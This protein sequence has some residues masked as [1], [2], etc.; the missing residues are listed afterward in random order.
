MKVIIYNPIGNSKGH[1]RVYTTGIVNGFL[2]LVFSTILITSEDFNSKDIVKG[3]LKKIKINQSTNPPINLT[4]NLNKIKYIMFLFKNSLS[5]FYLTRKFNNKNNI[6]LIAGGNTFFNCIY[7]LS[8]WD[9]SRYGLTIHNAD[10]ELNL[11]KKNKLKTLYK[12][13][14]KL[15]LKILTYS[16]LKIFCA[17]Y[18]QSFGKSIKS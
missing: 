14:T 7:L 6:I 12:L 1:S 15:L 2:E 11:N 5:S 10:F 13:L 3:D 17:T 4:K 8:I 9:K 16:N 18:L